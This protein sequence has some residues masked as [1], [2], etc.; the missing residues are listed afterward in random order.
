MVLPCYRAAPVA[1]HSV[2]EL[3]RALSRA[4]IREWEI[5]VVDDGGADF[6]P[7]FPEPN[8]R[9]TLLR[10]PRNRGKGAAVKAGM[11]RSRGRARIYTDAD[12]PYGA[13]IVAALAEFLLRTGP[14]LVIGDRS[15]PFSSH[16]RPAP[17]RRRALSRACSIAVGALLFRGFPDTQC[18][19]KGLRGEVADRLC[20]LLR[21]D[22][23]AFDI[24]LLYV[25]HCHGLEIRR[26]PVRLRRN[27]THSVRPVR[28]S[29]RAALDLLLILWRRS[30]GRYASRALRALAA[31]PPAE[32]ASGGWRPAR[33]P[34]RV[35]G[36]IE[37]GVAHERGAPPRGTG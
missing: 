16:P 4:G 6:P 2:R 35:R 23:F 10:L 27:V 14:D 32:A 21:T 7:D 18:G 29:L 36:S 17:L 22:R 15:L 3:E 12:L 30:R 5:I 25:A 11:R 1:L 37:P 9:V 34:S 31:A 20:P 26:V 19:L 13:S 33:D 8:G 28:D 24:E